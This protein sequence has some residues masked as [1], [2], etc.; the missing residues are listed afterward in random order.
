VARRP[1]LIYLVAFLAFEAIWLFMLEIDRPALFL[2]V[3]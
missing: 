2:F 3:P 1:W